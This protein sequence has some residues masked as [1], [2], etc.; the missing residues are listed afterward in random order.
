MFRF[1]LRG[2]NEL[3]GFVGDLSWNLIYKW[4]RGTAARCWA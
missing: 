4:L 2:I 3:E 1:I